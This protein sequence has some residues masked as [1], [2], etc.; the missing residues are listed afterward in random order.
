MLA[1]KS[2][3]LSRTVHIERNLFWI[4]ENLS[5]MLPITKSIWNDTNKL[6]IVNSLN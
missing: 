3:G 2:Y 5:K 4:T 1:E 6:S